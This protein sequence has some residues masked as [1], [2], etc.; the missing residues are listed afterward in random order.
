MDQITRI[1]ANFNDGIGNS[2]E[3]T[4]VI[5]ELDRK[6]MAQRTYEHRDSVHRAEHGDLVSIL[7]CTGTG[8]SGG[9]SGRL[10]DIRRTDGTVLKQTGAWSSNCFAVNSAFKDRPPII[11]VT[12][13]QHGDS[14]LRACHVRVDRLLHWCLANPADCGFGGIAVLQRYGHFDLEP[15]KADTPKFPDQC[16]VIEWFDLRASPVFADS[17]VQRVLELFR[18]YA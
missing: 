15:M 10:F 4:A 7:S 17:I 12:A 11:N 18:R 14:S 1:G 13:T 6:G 5:D 2:P 9:F 3:F 8:I 16:K